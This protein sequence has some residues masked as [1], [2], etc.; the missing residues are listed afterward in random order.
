MPSKFLTGRVLLL[1]LTLGLLPFSINAQDITI[2]GTTNTEV[3]SPDNQ[4]FNID[5]GDL[6]G[7]N[8]FHSFGNF[9]VSTNGSAQFNNAPDVENIISR[10]TGGNVSNLDG[11]I[12]AN[13]SANLFLINPSGIIFGEN[14]SLSI[15]GSFL[16]STADSLLFP[17]GIEFSASNDRGKPLLTINAPI[18]LNLRDNPANIVNRSIAGLEV[19]LGKNVA[20]IGGDVSVDGGSIAAPG[21]RVEL[22]G[23]TTAGIINFNSDNSLIFPEG[24]TRGDILLSNNTLVDVAGGEAGSIALNAQNIQILDGSSLVAGIREGL[25]FPGAQ[26]GDIEIRGRSLSLTNASSIFTSVFGVGNAGNI[27]IDVVD[28][29]ALDN[30]R[31][32]SSLGR[33][34]QSSSGNIDINSASVTLNNSSRID[35]S[36]NGIGN[37]GNIKINAIDGIALADNSNIQATGFFSATGNAGAI[38]I[39]TSSL[40]LLDNSGIVARNFGRGNAGDITIDASGDIVLKSTRPSRISSGGSIATAVNNPIATSGK[41]T[42]TANSLSLDG[43]SSIFTNQFG[44]N[45]GNNEIL[46]GTGKAG[47]INLVLTDSLSVTNG[48][49]I[50]SDTG[51][52]GNAGNI[53]IRAGENVTLDGFRTSLSATGISSDVKFAGIGNGGSVDIQAR[54]LSLKGGAAISTQTFGV[55]NAGKIEVNILDSVTIASG[56]TT[57]ANGKTI[58]TTSSGLFSSTLETATGKGGAIDVSTAK[59]QLSNVAAISASSKGTGDG[60]S[61]NINANT[62]DLDGGSQILATAFNRG[63]AG[64]ININASDRVNI[65]GNDLTYLDRAGISKILKPTF[66]P[67]ET[68]SPESGI[69]ANVQSTAR[70]NGGNINLTA[71]NLSLAKGGSIV[72]NTLGIGN[73]G[74][75]NINVR[76]AI[77]IAKFELIPFIGFNIPTG[78]NISSQVDSDAIGNA[79]KIDIQAKSLS[80]ADVAAIANSTLGIGNA[81]NISLQISDAISLE[82]LG[83]I[84]SNVEPGG[85]GIA[86]DINI[87][88]RSLTLKNGGTIQAGLFRTNGIIPGGRGEGGNIRINATDFVDVSGVN[89]TKFPIRGISEGIPS[90]IIADSSLGA[91]GNAGEIAINTGTLRI[92]DGG[93]I[94]SVTANSGKAGNIDINVRNLEAIGGGQISTA[95]LAE[96]NAGNINLNVSDRL[97]I[98][99]SDP[100]LF[101]RNA[102]ILQIEPF[103]LSNFADNPASGLFANTSVASTGNG[104]NITINK[105]ER[106]TISNGGS[107]AVDSFGRGNGGKGAIAAENLTLDK[108][109]SL[110]ASTAF[111]GGGNIELKIDNVLRLR[112]NSKIS[113]QAFNDANG[114]NI[115]IDAEFVVASLNQNNDIIARAEQGRGGN[116]QIDSTA[117]FGLEQRA[118]FPINAS[119]DIDASSEFGL[120]GNIAINTPD[121]N[122]TKGIDEA[123]ENLVEPEES[124]AQACSS[125]GSGTN[126][127]TVTGRGGMPVD[128]TKTLPGSYVRVSGEQSSKEKTQ[129]NVETFQ[130]TSLQKVNVVEQKKPIS[131]DEIIPARGMMIDE[132]GQVVLT[133]YPTPNSSDRPAKKTRDCSD[134]VF[135]D[136]QPTGIIFPDNFLVGA[137]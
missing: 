65:F 90:L 93:L 11:L 49:N 121:V 7:S 10:V 18:G 53:T 99:G 125:D 80:I 100:T 130:E 5:G 115:N 89:F 20:L 72:A 137:N 95:T 64:N 88:A 77:N 26:A 120:A 35:T 55:G 40:S 8:L 2:D 60:G 107:I 92:A 32:F 17:D 87:S 45:D 54:N 122:P 83:T 79:G 16:G 13:G 66:E 68:Q 57:D 67:F 24:L 70:A 56:F 39:S 117:I 104:G 38:D 29:V 124:V 59:L 85:R 119:N 102:K 136:I 46:S 129:S 128:P 109:A 101:D 50:S 123:S 131:S 81:G 42:I 27:A 75:I 19:N 116:I 9:S 114:G 113:A 103:A 111:G 118:S 62:I 105:P 112:N 74:N 133:R 71:G 69:F 6:A 48:A 106:F 91:Q 96:G 22:G 33:Q 52:R 78:S 132:K 25:G 127:F 84:R 44:L 1:T 63:N 36:T 86:G 37:A 94:R 108:N 134:R 43:I 51:G 61:I 23:L 110:S 47:D 31:I 12:S 98:S 76:D 58:P 126:T 34:S 15:G 4:N 73:A 28:R 97:N 3:T 21:G 82:N 135:N 30:S 41:V 14:A